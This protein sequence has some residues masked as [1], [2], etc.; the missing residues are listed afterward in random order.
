[1]PPCSL[2]YP[3]TA[4]VASPCVRHGH[5]RPRLPECPRAPSSQRHLP[6]HPN[7]AAVVAQSGRRHDP[8]FP[9]V[10]AR[11]CPNPDRSCS[12]PCPCTA[13]WSSVCPAAATASPWLRHGSAVRARAL[14][15]SRSGLRPA[16]PLDRAKL[17]R[18]RNHL[19]GSALS[20]HR[21]TLTPSYHAMSPCPASWLT[22]HRVAAAGSE[23]RCPAR[24]QEH[25]SRRAFRA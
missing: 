9:G 14:R 6:P 17:A 10:H 2:P 20:A 22:G 18:L 13:K 3:F 19:T 8:G 16:L 15:C 7:L 5:V 24:V 11:A 25:P 1:M 23:H 4:T 21:P 12:G